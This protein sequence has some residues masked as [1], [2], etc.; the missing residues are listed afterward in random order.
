MFIACKNEMND[1][2]IERANRIILVYD[3]CL[4]PEMPQ[5]WVSHDRLKLQIIAHGGF[6]SKETQ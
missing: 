1:S 5:S 3:W 4:C 6:S 2:S